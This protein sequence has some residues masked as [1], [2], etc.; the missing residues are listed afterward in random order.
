MQWK[1]IQHIPT[2]PESICFHQHDYLPPPASKKK[3]KN[4][5]F[6]KTSSLFSPDKFPCAAS[7]NPA[8]NS[9]RQQTIPSLIA[10]FSSAWKAIISSSYLSTPP[11]LTFIPFNNYNSSLAI[12]I[13]LIC[14][15]SL[16]LIWLKTSSRNTCSR[17]PILTQVP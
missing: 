3:K 16:R 15:Q 10:S 14:S 4:T 6:T 5:P 11:V 17:T 9:Y 7:F 13:C 1:N 2:N 12:Y 8:C